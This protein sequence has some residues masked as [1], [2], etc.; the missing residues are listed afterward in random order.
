MQLKSY[1]SVF[2]ESGLAYIVLLSAFNYRT[3]YLE[4]YA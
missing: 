2:Y 4:Q 3:G 1:L